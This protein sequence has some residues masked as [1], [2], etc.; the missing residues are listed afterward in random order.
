MSSTS[1]QYR[2]FQRKFEAMSC[3]EFHACD[4]CYKIECFTHVNWLCCCIEESINVSHIPSTDQVADIYIHDG[5]VRYDK[6]NL[7]VLYTR[8]SIAKDKGRSNKY[9][10]A[11]TLVNV[12]HIPSTD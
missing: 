9:T 12:S 4:V 3:H 8:T 1:L 5:D 10:I 11:Q 6:F 2:I 7:T